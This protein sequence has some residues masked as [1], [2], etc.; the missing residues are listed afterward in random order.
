MNRSGRPR[1]S[2]PSTIPSRRSARRVARALA[3]E[4]HLDP[5]PVADIDRDRVTDRRREVGLHRPWVSSLIDWRLAE[6]FDIEHPCL[7]AEWDHR[8]PVRARRRGGTEPA[9][10]E[11][12]RD[13]ERFGDRHAQIRALGAVALYRHDVRAVL[14]LRLRVQDGRELAAANGDADLDGFAEGEIETDSIWPAAKRC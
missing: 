1:E 9:F 11:I 13:G 10:V 14:T 12:E 3:G 7:A 6:W 2:T 4:H 8:P 5:N